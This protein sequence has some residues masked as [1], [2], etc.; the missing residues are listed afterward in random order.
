MNPV[1]ARVWFADEDLIQNQ[2]PYFH[3]N[4]SFNNGSVARRL[5]DAPAAAE[6]VEDQHYHC[7]HKQQVD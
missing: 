5:D 7:N 2:I 3:I 1:L 6:Q 4:S